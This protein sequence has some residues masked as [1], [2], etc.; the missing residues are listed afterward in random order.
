MFYKIGTDVCLFLFLLVTLHPVNRNN[1]INIKNKEKW[2][3]E[4]SSTATLR[5]C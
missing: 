5:R 3:T 1:I 2:K 4:L